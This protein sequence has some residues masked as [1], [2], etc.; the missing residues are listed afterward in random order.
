MARRLGDD[1]GYVQ[2]VLGWRSRRCAKARQAGRRVVQAG[3]DLHV[4]VGGELAV[5]HV[6][7]LVEVQPVAGVLAVRRV[8]GGGACGAPPLP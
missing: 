3:P 7:E 8:G 4:A 5:G 1:V 6:D 2:R